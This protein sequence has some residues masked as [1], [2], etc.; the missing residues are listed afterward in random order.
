MPPTTYQCL[1]ANIDLGSLLKRSWR[2][3][4]EEITAGAS[5][6]FNDS[7]HPGTV[8]AGH[9]D[10]LGKIAGTADYAALGIEFREAAE[11]PFGR[12]KAYRIAGLDFGQ[13][14]IR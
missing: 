7:D 14:F 10:E 1:V 6:S 5:E 8:A 13:D 4:H 2:V 12:F 9:R 3:R 11:Q